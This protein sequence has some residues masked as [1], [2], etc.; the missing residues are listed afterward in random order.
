MTDENRDLAE[1]RRA[2]AYWEREAVLRT[3][4]VASR[5][6]SQVIAARQLADA[7]E[8]AIRAGAIADADSG[9]MLRK[10]LDW[11]RKVD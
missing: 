3:T 7:V 2:A 1:A 11:F 5:L 4:T 9:L 10:Q 6:A 8:A